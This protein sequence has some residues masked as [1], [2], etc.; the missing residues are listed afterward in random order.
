MKTVKAYKLFKMKGGKLY[1]LYVNANQPI[2]MKK[3][4]EAE[5][6]PMDAKGKVK[7]KLGGLAFR[8]GWHSGD[9]PM[10][11]H[12][13]GK[14]GK[15]EKNKPNYRPDDQVWAEI[16]VPA[17]V[18]WQA[19]ANRRATKTKDGRILARSAQIDDQVPKGGYYKY[20]TNP[21]MTGEWIIS[22]AM[23]INRILSDEEVI[24]INKSFG[25]SDLPR[26]K[27]LEMS[28]GMS[29][30][31]KE[32]LERKV[33]ILVGKN[34]GNVKVMDVYELADAIGIE[35]DITKRQAQV[36]IKKAKDAYGY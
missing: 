20:K 26:L 4:V 30:K 35:Q 31:D 5:I 2:P 15:V 22:G 25:V 21:N 34:Q 23:K 19:E 9:M 12:I 16:E 8:P 24:K 13:G 18:N 28:E 10:A 36:M 32:T 14:Y 6:G 27:D 29:K 33:S 11:T 7:S 1:P 17:D 3:W